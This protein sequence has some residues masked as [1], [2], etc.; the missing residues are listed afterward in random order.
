M[1]VHLRKDSWTRSSESKF[2]RWGHMPY[3]SGSRSANFFVIQ[4]RWYLFCHYHDSIFQLIE[5]TLVARW[6][7]IS[8]LHYIFEFWRRGCPRIENLFIAWNHWFRVFWWYHWYGS[9]SFKGNHRWQRMSSVPMH[10]NI[11]SVIC[12]MN[13]DLNGWSRT[14]QTSIIGPHHLT[15]KRVCK[16]V[17]QCFLLT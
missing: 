8:W 7:N 5:E 17:G 10:E 6:I 9:L 4:M 14:L 13:V 2:T 11:K 3:Y 12:V 1:C 16:H 15:D